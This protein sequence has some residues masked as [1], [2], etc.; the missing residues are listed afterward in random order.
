M[1]SRK[2]DYVE[3][4]ERWG[5]AEIEVPRASSNPDYR[6][7]KHAEQFDPGRKLLPGTAIPQRL[8][9]VDITLLRIWAR[10]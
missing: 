9:I 2:P 6:P 7:L 8:R 5:S 1:P 3:D 10:V 4:A